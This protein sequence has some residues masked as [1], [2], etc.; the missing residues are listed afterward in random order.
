MTFCVYL[1]KA[2]FF[3][4]LG[5][6]SMLK[7]MNLTAI[8]YIFEWTLFYRSELTLKVSFPSKALGFLFFFETVYIP[9]QA[10]RENSKLLNKLTQGYN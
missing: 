9:L 10:A 8:S 5:K 2:K 7:D 1:E 6:K 4:L 3:H